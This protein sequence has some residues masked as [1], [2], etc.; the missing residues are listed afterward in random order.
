MP[1]NGV[2]N[3]AYPPVPLIGAPVPLPSSQASNPASI[4]V[5]LD[6]PRAMTNLIT[7]LL[8]RS[9]MSLAEMCRRLGIKPQSIQQY[10]AGR[11]MKPSAEWLARLVQVCG[12]RLIVEFPTT[13]LGYI[14][15]PG[16]PPKDE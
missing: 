9:G 10:K 3:S 12:G 4:A 5:V 11:R 1:D 15:E 14:A 8:S 16:R 2:N 7:Q 6:D 13:P